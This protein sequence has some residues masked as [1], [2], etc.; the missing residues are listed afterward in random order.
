[1]RSSS[2][3]PIESL[4]GYLRRMAHAN[5]YGFVSE[6]YN[7][8][9]HRYGRP[10]VEDL[11]GVAA[12][13]GVS[14]AELEVIAPAH[15]PGE[16]CREWRFERSRVDPFCPECL[17]QDEIW[18][19]AWRHCYVTACDIHNTRLQETCPRCKVMVN[20]QTGGYSACEC[21][22]PFAQFPTEKAAAEEILISSLFGGDGGD[23]W[24]N[25][26]PNDVGAFV[27]FLVSSQQGSRTGKLGKMPFPKT[28]GEAVVHVRRA[29]GLLSDWPHNF[30][31]EIIRR[32]ECAKDPAGTAAEVLGNWYQRLMQFSG[33]PYEPFRERLVAVIA[34]SHHG[35]YSGRN[36]DVE[37]SEWLSAAV[38]AKRIGIR[39]E[40]LVAA[41]AAGQ[42]PGAQ[43]HS[44]MGHTHTQVPSNLF[45]KLAAERE[46]VFTS[47]A[48]ADFL[49]VGKRHF[50]L[51]VELGFVGEIASEKM[52][53]LVDG[54]FDKKEL[55]ELVEKVS[56]GLR[57]RQDGGTTI[58]FAN[59][60]LRRTS[61]R[62]ALRAVFDEIK[63]GALVPVTACKETPLGQVEFSARDIEEVLKAS[64]SVAGYTAKEV[65]ELTGWKHECVTHWCKTGLLGSRKSKRGGAEAYDISPKDL[66][67]FQK[68]YVVL[69]DLAKEM[70][71]SSRALRSKLQE[72]GVEMSGELK[73]GK[74]SRGTL[75]KLDSLVR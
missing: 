9:G 23:L 13:L 75:V 8:L 29:G 74:T 58:A 56:S 64:G 46:A 33:V 11:D 59:L 22:M 34:K 54:R 1:M 63:R 18:K 39:A 71:T 53:P 43:R 49:G 42:V 68:R 69:A 28:V 5:A 55:S 52:H 73:V 57:S 44:G 36:V 17:A 24:I 21:G 30:D 47:K 62:H 16:A 41:V 72:T 12:K 35:P 38:A 2:P 51:L 19:A 4:S 14:L 10:L 32:F 37:A 26:P 31:A 60:N 25:G 67:T 50:K 45:E 66:V 15:A 40:R 70:G 20:P 61:D 48:A 27:H 7:R 65:S 6:F 3:K